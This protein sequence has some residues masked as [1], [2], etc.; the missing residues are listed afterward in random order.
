MPPRITQKNKKSAVIP[1]GKRVSEQTERQ[2]LGRCFLNSIFIM[3][4]KLQHQLLC[5]LRLQVHAIDA[6][7][8]LLNNGI[9]ILAVTQQELRHVTVNIIIVDGYKQGVA[10]MM[11]MT[12]N[13][14]HRESAAACFG[15]YPKNFLVVNHGC[16]KGFSAFIKGSL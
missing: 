7:V 4:S 3:G 14:S 8:G 1:S 6:A 5:F 12:G 16:S 13:L 15:E 2:I 11:H 10:G 9:G